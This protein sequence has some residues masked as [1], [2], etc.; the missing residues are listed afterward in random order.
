MNI[1]LPG[2]ATL[3]LTFNS[4]GFWVKYFSQPT[5]PLSRQL[6][7]HG[8]IDTRTQPHRKTGAILL[9]MKWADIVLG[10]AC[11]L[12]AVVA[13]QGWDYI[14]VVLISE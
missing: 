2:Q 8:V 11:F 7:T 4:E 14:N 12:K 5:R 13:N 6:A 10:L 3:Q 1:P 9:E